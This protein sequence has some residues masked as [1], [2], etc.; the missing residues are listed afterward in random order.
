MK[1]KDIWM[2]LKEA[3]REW[4]EDKASR[5]AAALA[6]YTLFSLAPL[7]VVVISIVGLFFGRQA[8]EGQIITQIS[9]LVGE[10]AAATIQSMIAN[11]ANT[12]ANI[13]A[14]IFGI[15]VLLLGASGVFG[16]LHD[17]LNAI[18]DVK[19]APGGGLLSLIRKRFLSFTMV[20]GIGF[21][22]LVSLVISAALSAVTTYF[23]NLLPGPGFALMLQVL[24]FIIFFGVTTLLFAMIY[25]YLPDVEIRWRDVWIGALVTSLL[26][27]IGRTLIGLYLGSSSVASVYGT[28]ASL[29]I[30]LIWIYYSAQILFYGAEFTQVYA[31]HFGKQIV[32]EK[33][34]VFEEPEAA[35]QPAGAQPAGAAGF[36]AIPVTGKGQPAEIRLPLHRQYPRTVEPI[37][38]PMPGPVK[39][40]TRV[41]GALVA[42]AGLTGVMWARSR[43]TRVDP[44][45]LR[46]AACPGLVPRRRIKYRG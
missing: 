25:K 28:A 29:V 11:T 46:E 4:S 24:N 6:Y 15:V 39:L 31:R 13:F 16:A 34:A 14:T 33:G 3:F 20:L 9:G 42:A 35:S 8:A 26:F 12:G 27:A 17:S 10:D 40:F 38:P 36:A 43:S 23:G 37:L 19:E 41:V 5:L 7:L 30:I 32:P 1:I 2:L 44:P 21:L 18:W 45:A 22:L